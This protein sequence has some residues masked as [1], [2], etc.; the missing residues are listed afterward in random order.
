M[1]FRG[2]LEDRTVSKIRVCPG[3]Y[4]KGRPTQELILHINLM[5]DSKDA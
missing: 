5:N 4:E 3:G 2:C 1:C